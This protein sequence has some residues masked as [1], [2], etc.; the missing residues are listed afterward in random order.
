MRHKTPSPRITG[1][2]SERTID[3]VR[4]QTH[5][6]WSMHGKPPTVRAVSAAAGGISLAQVTAA[7]REL[8]HR[9]VLRLRL[10][11]RHRRLDW[12]RGVPSDM[13]WVVRKLDSAGLLTVGAEK[14]L[15]VLGA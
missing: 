5:N 1:C 12:M 13:E 10:A 4:V 6:L 8:E 2:A 3:I 9:G 11:G 7:W 14:A 15:E